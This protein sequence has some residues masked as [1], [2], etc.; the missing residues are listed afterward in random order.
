[1]ES[2]STKPSSF[3]VI[4]EGR[5]TFVF[6]RTKDWEELQSI[7][8][9]AVNQARCASKNQ[10]HQEWIPYIGSDPSVVGRAVHLAKRHMGFIVDGKVVNEVWGELNFLKMAKA[11]PHG[12]DTLMEAIAGEVTVGW[13]IEDRDYFREAEGSLVEKSVEGPPASGVSSDVG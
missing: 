2:I 6:R 13:T 11:D 4:L 9:A 5:P 3:V 7:R 1:M 8:T 10:V 12:F